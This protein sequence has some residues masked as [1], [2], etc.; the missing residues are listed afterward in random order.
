MGSF[1]A[2]TITQYLNYAAIAVVV[3][4]GL[5]GF[6]RGTKKS[7]YYLI[8]TAIVFVGG[9]LVMGKAADFLLKFDISSVGV[10]INSIASGSGVDFGNAK[11]LAEIIYNAIVSSAPQLEPVL[12]MGDSQTEQ[13]VFGLIGMFVKLIYFILLI[14]LSIT[15]FKWIFDIIWAI[16]LRPRKKNGRKPKKSFLSRLI[17][18]AIGGAKGF[19][20]TLLIFF[21][22][23]GITS[24]GESL[25][26]V[27]PEENEEYG[28]IMV[29]DTATLVKLGT[30]SNLSENT[31]NNNFDQVLEYLGCYRESIFGKVFGIEIKETV[32]L[33][34]YIFDS[35]F[36]FEVGETSVKIR[37]ELS[38]VANTFS[39]L[40]GLIDLEEGFDISSFLQTANEEDLKEL[41]DTLTS[42]DLLKVIVPVAVEVAVYGNLSEDGKSFS[43]KWIEEGILT[44]EEVRDILELDYIGDVKKLGYTFVEAK[45]IVMSFMNQT[46]EVD[47]I[48]KFLSLDANSVKKLFK[49]ISEVSSI[50]TFATIGVSFL[51]NNEE[52]KNSLAQ[53]GISLE[54]LLGNTDWASELANIGDIYESFVELG[55]QEFDLENIINTFKELGMEEAEEKVG[56]LVEAMFNSTIIANSSNQIVKVGIQGALEGSEYSSIFSFDNVVIDANEVKAVLLAMIT[57]MKADL[58]GDNPMDSLTSL[59]ATTVDDLSKYLSKS[60]IVTNSLNSIF[61]KLASSVEIFKEGTTLEGVPT[62]TWVDSNNN[63]VVGVDGKIEIREVWEKKWENELNHLLHSLRLLMSVMNNGGETNNFDLS[64]LNMELIDGDTDPVT[65][66]HTPG[67]AVH[68]A[69]SEF[70][71]TNLSSLVDTFMDGVNFLGEG[72]ELQKLTVNEWQDSN[73]ISHLLH[74]IRLLISIMDNSNESSSSLSLLNNLTDNK[75]EE[76]SIHLSGSKFIRVNLATIL[77]SLMSN[78]NIFDEGAELQTLSS[79][80]W[81][82]EELT[83]LFNSIKL[84]T[85]LTEETG[86]GN[87]P[88]TKLDQEFIEG[89]LEKDG[90]AGHL[91]KS[92]FIRKNLAVLLDTVM[93]NAN[94]L[95]TGVD[96]ETLDE[97]EWNENELT[98]LFYSVKDLTELMDNSE[99]NGGLSYFTKLNDNKIN[100]LSNHLSGSKFIRYNL[101]T[102]LDSTLDDIDLMGAKFGEFDDWCDKEDDERDNDVCVPS[103]RLELRALLKSVKIITDKTGSGGDDINSLLSLNDHELDTLLSSKIIGGTLVNVLENNSEEG[104]QLEILVGIKETDVEWYTPFEWYDEDYVYDVNFTNE[105]NVITITPIEGATKYDIYAGDIKVSSS[106]KL[107]KDI[108][109]DLEDLENITINDIDRVVAYKEGELRKIF[110]AIGALASDLTGEEGFSTSSITSLSD[111]DINNILVSDILCKSIINKLEDLEETISIPD[112]D[113]KSSDLPTKLNA[114]E[115]T[116]LNGE[117]IEQGELSKCLT[118]LKLTLG[119]GELDLNNFD[120]KPIIV[121]KDEILKSEILNETIVQQIISKEA[122]NVPRKAS[123]KVAATTDRSGWRNT[124]SS[125]GSTVL[126]H[127]E[128]SRLLDAINIILEENQEGK[129]LLTGEMDFN[130]NKLFKDEAIETILKSLVLSETVVTKI[131]GLENDTL[132]FPNSLDSLESEERDSWFNT[133]D[134]NGILENE[135]ELKFLL[136]V[137]KTL[138]GE[139]GDIDDLDLNVDEVLNMDQEILLHSQVVSESVIHQIKLQNNTI[140]KIPEEDLENNKLF[141]DE[142]NEI[143]NRDVWYNTYNRNEISEGVFEYTINKIGE[144]GKLL[145]LFKSILNKMKE[146]DPEVSFNSMNFDVSIIFDDAIQEKAL[147][148]LVLSETIINKIY[149]ISETNPTLVIPSSLGST[150]VEVNRNEWYNQYTNNYLTNAGELQFLLTAA[151]VLVGEDSFENIDVNVDDALKIDQGILLHSEIISASIVKQIYSMDGNSVNIPTT[152]LDGNSLLVESVPN[153]TLWNTQ[154]VDTYDEG[155]LNYKQNKQGEIGKLLTAVASILDASGPNATFTEMNFDLSLIFN[156]NIQRKAL[157]SLVISETIARKVEVEATKEGAILVIPNYEFTNN[158]ITFNLTN[159]SNRKPWF[160]IY[161][162]KLI[163]EKIQ[164]DENGAIEYVLESEGEIARLLDAVNAITNGGSFEGINFDLTTIFDREIQE[165]VLKSLVL[166]ETIVSKIFENTSMVDNIPTKDSQNRDLYNE[167]DSKKVVASREVW[168]N[169]YSEEVVKEGEIAHFLNAI[170]ILVGEGGIFDSEANFNNYEASS[171]SINGILNIDFMDDTKENNFNNSFDENMNMKANKFDVLFA[172]AILE[173]IVSPLVEDVATNTMSSF[174]NMPAEIT[175]NWKKLDCYNELE[176]TYDKELYDLQTFIESLYL[177]NKGGID[178]MNIVSSTPSTWNSEILGKAFVNSRIFRGSTAQ[179]FHMIEQAFETK[180]AVVN[181]PIAISNGTYVYTWDSFNQDRYGN[182]DLTEVKEKWYL[183]IYDS[184]LSNEITKNDALN[185]IIDDINTFKILTN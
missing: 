125:D 178:Y 49:N 91:S 117:V 141:I 17:G 58:L 45:D 185:A 44:E 182:Y 134:E 89:D 65:L 28:L 68:L 83:H 114:W 115:N 63:K 36:S 133:Y 27:L 81:T 60:T 20:Y 80:E 7:I 21:L 167:V 98:N 172:S 90:I 174:M 183:P 87:S 2:A 62:E 150:Y 18:F 151:D 12:A 97:D 48:Q 154:F 95:G 146:E 120:L 92:R 166:S 4:F 19:A 123:Y 108:S 46:E 88:F 169:D 24:I 109:N 33:D 78:V 86:D 37:K 32:K 145:D 121:N 85:D 113:L 56:K 30:S 152:D 34:E 22:V 43:T 39:K 16:F 67:L 139:N 179:L 93:N 159:S 64:K 5:F 130:L 57:I 119:G 163:D 82:S 42:L 26:E 171:I 180:Y 175:Y 6:I 164:Y 35:L 143:S 162:H 31:T 104:K 99:N 100:D 110:I 112:G 181:D 54:D 165:A 10:D 129:I 14:V 170:N 184:I 55:L 160:N 136:T 94:L 23:A 101:D 25:N 148:S 105:G 79:E 173:N 53:Y 137:I 13:L 116:Y 176:N 84:I 124:Y 102:I 51:I 47:P 15:I 73:E 140:I 41:I 118:A 155:V 122:I 71:T 77:D 161:S 127:G 66:K 50:N 153:Y 147:K 144:A 38:T 103:S 3:L 149:T 76:L 158:E 59:N 135:G 106:R 157:N 72:V 126:K 156:D 11:S 40:N 29:G 1:D 74:S 107:I 111:D 168:Y 75:I 70:I 131:Y 96:L 132:R 61:S 52:L 9:W 69:G 138:L 8:A 177:M 128:L 142:M